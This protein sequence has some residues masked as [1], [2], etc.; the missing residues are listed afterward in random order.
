MGP[1]PIFRRRALESIVP[2]DT[3]YLYVVDADGVASGALQ[4]LPF[5]RVMP[6]PDTEQNAIYFYNSR[7]RDGRLKYVSYHFEAHPE[8]AIEDPVFS[9]LLDDLSPERRLR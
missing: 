2:L 6:S 5:F 3:E 7:E 1:N 9:R 8:S 4:V